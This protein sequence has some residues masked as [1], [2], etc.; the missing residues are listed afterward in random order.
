MQLDRVLLYELD[1]R[2]DEFIGLKADMRG[3]FVTDFELV[4][5]Q[6]TLKKY[7]FSTL[8]SEPDEAPSAAK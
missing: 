6:E 5:D 3:K 7:H 2:A 8:F 4:Y 1:H